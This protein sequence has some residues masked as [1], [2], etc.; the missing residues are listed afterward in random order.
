KMTSGKLP[1]VPNYFEGRL[2]RPLMPSPAK[3]A[4]RLAIRVASELAS[5]Q[6]PPAATGGSEIQTTAELMLKCLRRREKE[7]NEQ[8]LQP[9]ISWCITC[10]EKTRLYGNI[11]GCYSMDKSPRWTLGLRPLYLERQPGC[12]SCHELHKR[13]SGRFV[14]V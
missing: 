8:L 3:L 13:S 1:W 5:L 10:R 4:E 14:P 2:W 6:C 11:E 12:R 7:Q 9:V